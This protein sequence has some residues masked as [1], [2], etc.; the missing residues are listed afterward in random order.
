MTYPIYLYNRIM[1]KKWI[2]KLYWK[3][4]WQVTIYG[5]FNGSVV[6]MCYD[7]WEIRRLYL[8]PKTKV[9]EVKIIWEY[10]SPN[11]FEQIIEK[12]ERKI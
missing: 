12:Y 3:Y 7:K 8:S 11:L 1:I 2:N 6:I 10:V 9:E 5:L 4:C